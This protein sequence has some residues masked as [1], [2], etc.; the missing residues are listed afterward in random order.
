[1]ELAI[2]ARYAVPFLES[3]G[4]VVER[5]YAGT[6][7]SSLDMAGISI[8]ILGLNDEWLRWLD[9]ETSAPAWPNGP[10][11]P[12]RNPKAE[13]A[14]EPVAAPT[15]SIPR[16]AQTETGRRVRQAIESACKALIDAEEE[17]TEMDRVTGDG[18]LGISMKRA[19]EAMLASDESYPLDN[20]PATLKQLGHTVQR[21]MGGAS[22]PLYGALFLRCGIVLENS[23]RTGLAS[24]IEALHQGCLAIS[25]M[26]GAKRGDRTMLDALIPFVE[27]LD[28][29]AE[30]EYRKTLLSAVEAAEG[31]ADA[32]ARMTPRVGRSSYLGER[33]IGHPDPG[34]KAVAIWLRGVCESIGSQQRK[35]Q[36]M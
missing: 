34:A 24:W 7:L 13:I 25:E 31:G 14:I 16:G 20:I 12:P 35:E 15:P 2:V 1:M 8:S 19:A 23:K 4:F 18:D 33:V 9:A 6:F 3:R 10:K 11:Q 30:G 29:A 26:G 5:I 32:T 27:S 21:V 22:G 28:S 36:G 17:L